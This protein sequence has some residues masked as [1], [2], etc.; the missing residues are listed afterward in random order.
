MRRLSIL[1]VALS[2]AEPS[3][4]FRNGILYR[5]VSLSPK[6]QHIVTYDDVAAHH[7]AQS[8]LHCQQKPLLKSGQKKNIAVVAAAAAAMLFTVIALPSPCHASMNLPL[9]SPSELQQSLITLLDN[10]SNS[11]TKGMIVYAISFILWTMTVGVTTP[12]ETAAG[13]AFP[14]VQSIPLSAIGKIGGAFLQYSLAKYIFRDW[15]RDKMKGNEWMTKIDKSFQ[16]HPFRVALIWRF[17]P[18]PEFVKNIGPSLVPTLKTRYQVLATLAHGLP[19]TVLWSIM[20]NEAAAVARGKGASVF[21]KR[22]V[23]GISWIGLFVS[24][25]LFGM[26][27]KGLG[28]DAKIDSNE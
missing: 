21:L 22:M 19:F 5:P 15:A 3:S 9:P 4:S 27:I 11:G 16:S 17:S 10:L 25:T 8:T 13:M 18:L 7:S 1:L 23:A 2:L 14:L 6:R 20:G 26:W 24:P 28:D 12:I